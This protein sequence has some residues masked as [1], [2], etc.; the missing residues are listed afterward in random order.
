M[1]KD[2]REKNL[3]DKLLFLRKDMGEGTMMRI[4]NF[5]LYISV[6]FQFFK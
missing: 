4:F 3:E 2:R 6:L 5:T 1:G